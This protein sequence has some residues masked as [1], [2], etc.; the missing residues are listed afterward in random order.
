MIVD[1]FNAWI[2]IVVG[3]ILSVALAGGLIA[4]AVA[5]VAW[6]LFG[7]HRTPNPPPDPD[8]QYASDRPL[9]KEKQHA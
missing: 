1:L 6:W 3:A 5:A 2:R 7:P 9:T 4:A 8:P